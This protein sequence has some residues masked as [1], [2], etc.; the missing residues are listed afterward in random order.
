M[1]GKSII[2]A[3]VR[4][5]RG[6]GIIKIVIEYKCDAASEWIQCGGMQ[7]WHELQNFEILSEI[8]LDN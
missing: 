1:R 7:G 4:E 8:G 3:A 6:T 2:G 5:L